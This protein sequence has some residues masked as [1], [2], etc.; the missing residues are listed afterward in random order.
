MTIQGLTADQSV[1]V[2]TYILVPKRIGRKKAE[3]RRDT[4]IK[5]FRRFNVNR[6]AV[7]GR[8]ADI[9]DATHRKLLMGEL[10]KAEALIGDNPKKLDFDT[11]LER[12]VD[13]NTAVADHMRQAE[14]KAKYAIAV[15]RMDAVENG[16]ALDNIDE[17][18]LVWTYAENTYQHGIKSNDQSALTSADKSFDQL[19]DLIAAGRADI[20]GEGREARRKLRDVEIALQELDETLNT[21][22]TVAHVPPPVTALLGAVRDR[23]REGETAS[24]A[25]L[26]GKAAAAEAALTAARTAGTKAIADR[27]KWEEDH[28]R[29]RL[30][31]DVME[32]HPMAGDPVHVAPKF[33]EVTDAYQAAAGRAL[34][35]DYAR[36]SS[37]LAPVF[38]QLDTALKFADDYQNF[39]AVYDA[40]KAMADALPDPASRTHAQVKTAIG[41]IKRLLTEAAT[42]RD[43]GGMDV[44]LQK[45]EK[46]RTDAPAVVKLIAQEDSFINS[47]PKLATWPSAYED[48][49]DIERLMAPDVA[50]IKKT[51][52]DSKA[53]A[54]GGDIGLACTMVQHFWPYKR[55][56]DARKELIEKYLAEKVLF[57][58]RRN[59]TRHFKGRIAVE[60]Y[61]QRLKEDRV[62]MEAWEAKLDVGMALDAATALK[63]QH[64]DMKEQAALGKTYVEI[65][66][67]LD[68]EIARLEGGAA[69]G[70]HATASIALTR[71]LMNDALGLAQRDDWFQAVRL[72]EGA[73]AAL[74]TGT[75]AAKNAKAIDSMVETGKLDTIAT[76][77][78]SAYAQFSKIHQSI[79]G[80]DTDNVFSDR[81]RAADAKAS[82]ARGA[83]A[84]PD[85]GPAQARATLEEA[86]NDCK[87]VMTSHV[88]RR[89]FLVRLETMT[90]KIAALKK[91]NKDKIIQPEI[92]AAQG[93][94]DTAK[95]LGDPPGLD[96]EGARAELAKAEH[97]IRE[98]FGATTNYKWYKKKLAKFEKLQ[99]KF[100]N[101]KLATAM[102]T[103]ATRFGD[104]IDAIKQAFADR[105]LAVRDKKI[106]E[107]DQ[108]Y[109]AYKRRIKDYEDAVK[110]YK[111]RITDNLGDEMNSPGTAAL[112]QTIRTEIAEID[113]AMNDHLYDAAFY[114]ILRTGNKIATCKTLAAAH[115]T[116]LP[117]KAAATAALDELKDR[118]E[119][120]NGPGRDALAELQ[121]RYDG[122]IAEETRTNYSGAQKRLTG[123]A[124][125]C[126]AVAPLFDTFDLFL[127]A[128][129]E[130]ERA[131]DEIAGLGTA[132]IAPLFKRIESRR[133]NALRLAAAFDFAAAMD[134][135][136]ELLVD[137][138][139][140]RN[141]LQSQAAFGAVMD[142][143]KD[144]EDGDVDD[145]KMSI[146][147]ARATLKQL[148]AKPMALF[149]R[150][151]L[152][153][154]GAKIETASD[155]ADDDFDRARDL[156]TEALDDCNTLA[157]EMGRFEQFTDTVELARKLLGDL[158][159]THP[160]ADF[161]HDEVS[162]LLTRVNDGMTAVRQDPTQRT[163]VRDDVETVISTC[164]DL[165]KVLD[166]HQ[167]WHLDH[168]QVTLDFRTLEKHEERRRVVAEM[169]AIR[170][171]LDESATKAAAR[172]HKEAAKQIS[173]ARDHIAQAYLEIKICNNEAPTKDELKKLMD[174]PDGFK[175][176]DEVINR[177]DADT[178]RKVM[179]TAFEARFGC[180]L[181]LFASPD[182]AKKGKQD[183]D[184]GKKA[185]NIQRFY[186]LMSALPPSSTLDNDSMLVFS[187]AGEKADGSYY[188]PDIKEIAMREGEVGDSGLYG[189]GLEQE[190]GKDR[191]QLHLEEGEPMSFFSWN[192]LHEVGHAVDDKLGFMNQHGATL[193]GWQVF[194][195]N[196]RPVADA[197]ATELSFDS[198]YIAEYI[199]GGEGSEPPIP[200][201]VGCDPEEWERRRRE[202]CIWIDRVR[203]K[204]KPWASDSIAK[205]ATTKTGKVYHES[206]NR[207]WACYDYAA[208]GVGVSG[209]QFRAPGEWFSELYAAVHSK[210]LKNSHTHYNTIAGAK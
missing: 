82:G 152:T 143:L 129:T 174:A 181:D 125:S 161:T 205:Q 192:T 86:I 52:V 191:S 131:V 120:E 79:D 109:D 21:A 10:A 65:K 69:G 27:R 186:E 208:R 67:E 59:E 113:R 35:H 206:Y 156:L 107:A 15:Q 91:E 159:N 141:A 58:Q 99:K 14:V 49:G 48:G 95:N 139:T 61:Y 160:Q 80:F 201:P 140:A 18:E 168:R 145:L 176:L 199:S 200:E 90:A 142:Q 57:H 132:S 106:D 84:Q 5:E 60:P 108:L 30:R 112:A 75:L 127:T 9:P 121:A 150:D 16:V 45:L 34:V 165:Q 81:L 103:E 78:D 29:F 204:K 56:M 138:A 175:L 63:G 72:M 11:A 51:L 162:D 190:L 7:A 188:R 182:K 194:G 19:F 36:A 148:G 149:V 53:K 85:P 166:A 20:Q 144:V 196:V 169:T 97:Q 23:L 187:H 89:A 38:A 88:E 47:H 115:G 184:L 92:D 55:G 22:F 119:A 183:T 128:R 44:A 126:S 40:R 118:D 210:K 13:I 151:A 31:F 12:L 71:Q 155:T 105:R 124:D 6:D 2:E 117:V 8:I 134:L 178:Q 17:I 76:D 135:F 137:C 33:K 93:F 102:N 179:N 110:Q 116:W 123:F 100:E 198:N 74:A 50:L 104:L 73:K 114:M 66:D 157:G 42:F 54:D 39:T 172:D 64:D 147:A 1:F 94:I 101:A 185:P 46:I 171:C 96:F 146:E 202:A 28:A 68:V 41:D 83:A 70:D 26:P 4:A 111:K 164:R 163:R 177:L 87:A 37:D 136:R 32:A 170:N 62:R 153:T 193:A 207:D 122:A 24:V 195:A 209:Y 77:F 43:G 154:V 203:H 158:L 197:I 167:E 130:A 3:A 189:F 180:K 133:D 98:G 25:D 173:R